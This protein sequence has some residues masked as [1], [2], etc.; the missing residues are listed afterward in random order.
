MKWLV[1]LFF[2]AG[3]AHKQPV[4]V[5]PPE[6]PPVGERLKQ[7]CPELVPAPNSELLSDLISS[8]I[9]NYG[10]YHKCKA[11][12]EAWQQWYD[13]QRTNQEKVKK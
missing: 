4:P 7:K 10:E 3:C 5:K 9:K 11:T 8:V 13:E 12:V 1:L 6:F 2:L